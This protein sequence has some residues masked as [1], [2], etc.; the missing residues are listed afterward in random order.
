M[1]KKLRIEFNSDYS[2]QAGFCF[3]FAVF[4]KEMVSYFAY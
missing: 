3:V 4:W 1:D 2:I